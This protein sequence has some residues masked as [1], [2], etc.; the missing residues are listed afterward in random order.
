M[1]PD[2]GA[3]E[4]IF[5]ALSDPTRRRV[6]ERLGR[7]PASVSELAGPFDM[8][9]PSFMQHLKVLESVGLVRSRKEG[10]VRTYRLSPR[11]LKRAEDWLSE[12]RALWER[13]LDQFDDYVTKLKESR[14]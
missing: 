9:L 8:A 3:V 13:R 2:A 6:V 11:E 7:G 4:A 5:R 10:R 14:E 1:L 12:Q